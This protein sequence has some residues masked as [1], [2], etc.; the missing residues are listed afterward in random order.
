[1]K[2]LIALILLFSLNAQANCDWSKGITPGPNKTFIYS[3]E[4]HQEVGKLVQANKDLQKA[5]QLKDLAIQQSDTRVALWEKTADN[6]QDRLIK[7]D[8]EEKHNEILYF[9]LGVATTFLAG[10]AAA[11]LA[12]H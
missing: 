11:K 2:K 5:I 12:G 4:C 9:A 7:M 10:Y 8:S 1:M 3:E 6:E